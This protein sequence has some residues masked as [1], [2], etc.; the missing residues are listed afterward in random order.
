M[1]IEYLEQSDGDFLLG[2]FDGGLV[3]QLSDCFATEKLAVRVGGIN[4]CSD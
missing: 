3:G 1:W 2:R 4:H